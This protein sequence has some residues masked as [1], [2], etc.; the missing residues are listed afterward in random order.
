MKRN[1]NPNYEELKAAYEDLLAKYEAMSHQTEAASDL[2]E[3]DIRLFFTRYPAAKEDAAALA[4]HLSESACADKSALLDA[5]VAV[6]ASKVADPA[7]L[8]EDDDFLTRYIFVSP[9][10]KAHFDEMRMMRVTPS[11]KGF[12]TMLSASKPSSFED[13]GELAKKLF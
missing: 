13:A 4:D 2:T 1:E 11:A 8:A 10:V 6:L 3:E 5:Y 9:K 12:A 7:K